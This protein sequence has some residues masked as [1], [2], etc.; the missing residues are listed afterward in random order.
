[1]F[2][3]EKF[4]FLPTKGELITGALL[5]ISFVFFMLRGFPSALEWL[6]PMVND[7]FAHL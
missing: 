2:G 4:D 6:G 5:F 7:W 3:M 1:M